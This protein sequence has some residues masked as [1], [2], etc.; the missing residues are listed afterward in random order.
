[1]G[2][3]P[4]RLFPLGEDEAKDL[5]KRLSLALRNAQVY[6]AAHAVTATSVGVLYDQIIN[7]LDRYSEIE[8]SLADGR[9]LINGVAC[10]LQTAQDILIER[11]QAS[12]MDC[13]R[14]REGLMRPELTQFTQALASGKFDEVRKTGC[15]NITV[16][17]SVYA[18]VRE[19]EKEDASRGTG[20]SD[21]DGA[22]VQKRPSAKG[23]VKSFDLDAVLGDL[24]AGDQSGDQPASGQRAEVD[25]QIQ[26]FLQ[27]KRV[28]NEQM[29]KMQELV[30]G[31]SSSS[32][33]LTALQDRFLATGGSQ[34]EWLAFLAESGIPEA[35]SPSST[36]A[37]PDTAMHSLLRQMEALTQRC[38]EEQIDDQA[39]SA[40]LE[41]IRYEIDSL[42]TRTRRNANSLVERVDADRDTV[43][44]IEQ[45]ARDS[46]VGIHLSREELLSSLAEINQELVQP[47]TT[48][49]ALLELLSSGRIGPVA[50]GQQEVVHT[51]VQSL[52]R[53]ETLIQYLQ[54][55]S[56][57][58]RGLQPN[59]NLL[60]DVYGRTTSSK[61]T[62]SA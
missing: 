5:C 21:R 39:L 53:L 28:A 13:F 7:L 56:G 9:I 62:P 33:G 49:T 42:L 44:E 60:D 26:A 55:I 22:D 15:A 24:D 34:R 8:W 43:A 52:E 40:S 59:R 3:V 27:Q 10:D 4:I 20:R 1:M 47:L 37:S 61:G 45:R 29:R 23:G 41:M 38:E 46:G 36:S 58:P 30:K 2:T 48:S 51:A 25:D 11:M 54:Q 19:G 57:V 16:E 50:E 32:G 35:P 17:G 14:I 6:G 31:A 12:D 18:R